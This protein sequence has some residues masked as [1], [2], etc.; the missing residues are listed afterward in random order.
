[1]VVMEME[2]NDLAGKRA[3]QTCNELHARQ[4]EKKVTNKGD[5]VLWPIH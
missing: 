3:K 1:M 2:R 5:K 4:K